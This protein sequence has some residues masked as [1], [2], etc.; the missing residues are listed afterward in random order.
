M[1]AVFKDGIYWFETPVL[2]NIDEWASQNGYS[3]LLKLNDGRTDRTAMIV[4]YTTLETQRS[5]LRRLA[6]GSNGKYLFQATGYDYNFGRL[7]VSK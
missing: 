6:R 5:V 2:V 3:S 7:M 4:A 1:E